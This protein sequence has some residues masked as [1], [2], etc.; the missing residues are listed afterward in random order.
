MQYG[1][2]PVLQ[3]PALAVEAGEIFALMGPNGAGKSTLLRIMGLL[4]R[5][6]RGRVWFRGSLVT[7]RQTL[8]IRRRMASV[9]QEPLLLNASVYE[10]A[11]LGLKLR[12]VDRRTAARQ[13]E[14]WLERFGIAHLRQRPVHSL[15]GGEA[16]RTSLV[17]AL[18]LAPD[19][20]LLDEPFA[21]L[22]PPS[23]EALLLDLERILRDS[24]ITTVF[25]THERHEALTLGDRVA[26]FFAGTPVQLGTPWEVFAHPATE[27]VAHFVGADMHLPGTVHTAE[28]G[29]A[30]VTTPIGTVEAPADL[31]PGSRVTLCLRP[32]DLRLHRADQAPLLSGTPNL[33]S[34]TIARITPWGGQ[35]RVTI[36]SGVS[37]TALVTRRCLAELALQPGQQVLVT[38]KAAAVHVIYHHERSGESMGKPET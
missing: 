3:V 9:L 6:T 15:S 20:L 1:R 2:V 18:A 13:V 17:R 30:R 7:R 19:L 16:Q 21:A 31:P 23:R 28:Q 33:V 25:V 38:F 11:A 8:T 26:V 10:N 22:D 34:G 12:R 35:A 27:A 5:P 29:L 24:G 36:S 4:Q 37:L 32:E 14:P